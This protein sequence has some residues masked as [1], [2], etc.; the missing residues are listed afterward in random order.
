MNHE[1]SRI[2]YG[3]TAYVETTRS[4]IDALEHKLS[5]SLTGDNMLCVGSEY[6]DEWIAECEDYLKSDPNSIIDTD[7]DLIEFL[8]AVQDKSDNDV[9][10]F[11][12]VA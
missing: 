3:K 6:I 12:F 11:I 8:R 2:S 4:T 1:L 5:Y 10:D 9:G 7:K